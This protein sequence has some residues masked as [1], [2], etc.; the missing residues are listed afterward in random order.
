[1]L[2]QPAADGGA[3]PA[4]APVPADIPHKI[5]NT[6]GIRASV[7]GTSGDAGTSGSFECRVFDPKNPATLTSTDAKYSLSVEV[8]GSR[9]YPSG[10]L[11]V[12]AQKASAVFGSI[13]VLRGP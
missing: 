7:T 3:T 1:V 8:S 11:G 12:Y 10:D 9:W 4:S 5:G 13:D 2:N 6:I